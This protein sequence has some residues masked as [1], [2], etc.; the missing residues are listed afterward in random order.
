[1]SVYKRV[2]EELRPR[3]A[4]P[5]YTFNPRDLAKEI[6]GLMQEVPKSSNNAVKPMVFLWVHE[7]HR[8]FHDRQVSKAVGDY[9]SGE[10]IPEMVRMYFKGVKQEDWEGK[11]ILFCDWLRFGADERIYEPVPDIPRLAR[12]FDEYLD[13]Y[14]LSDS[15]RSR[16][17]TLVPFHDHCLHLV[18]ITRILR[19]PRS[20]ALLVGVGG[21]G[22]RSLTRLGASILEYQVFE[23]EVTKTYSMQ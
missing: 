3:P 14:N 7:V 4:T 23:I 6:Q 22:K 21:T 9:F 2:C 16:H 13:E 20:N 8:C 17:M 11:T 1:M 18:R 19:Q 5:H 12:I 10:L 15:N